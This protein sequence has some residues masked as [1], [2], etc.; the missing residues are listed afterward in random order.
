MACEAGASILTAPF[1][2]YITDRSK[3]RQLPFIGGLLLLAASMILLTLARSTSVYVIGR[4]LQGASTAMVEVAGS[5]L[6]VDAIAA[7][8]LGKMLGYLG[9]ATSLGFAFGPL[10]G[11]VIY[12][13]AGYYAVFGLAFAIIALDLLLRVAMVEPR[14]AQRWRAKMSASPE[15]MPGAQSS[16]HVMEVSEPGQGESNAYLTLLK[17]PRI[18]IAI[19]GIVVQALVVAAFDAV[20]QLL[21]AT[22]TTS[23]D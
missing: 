4:L 6:V 19:W 3:S 22:I 10:A 5:A 11:G 23:S 2:G 7:D 1:F 9:A 18:L 14:T 8:G 13:L 20:C 17:Q 15:A 12:H 21:T 16:N